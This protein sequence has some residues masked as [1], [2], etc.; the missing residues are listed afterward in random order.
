M[1][2]F[3]L[4]IICL[5]AGLLASGPRGEAAQRYKHTYSKWSYHSN[6]KY[7]YR[8]YS[9]KPNHHHYAIYR[10]S[11]GKRV[12]YYNPVK[13]SYW[14]Y[15]DMESKA[16]SLLPEKWRLESFNDIPAEAFP[17]PSKEMPK[18]PGEDITFEPPDDELPAVSEK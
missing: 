7:H 6:Y 16:Y 9:Y 5:G 11:Y 10:P 4:T 3:L 2:R 1:R 18:I 17:K 12:Y 14:G 13:K 8:S 15:Y